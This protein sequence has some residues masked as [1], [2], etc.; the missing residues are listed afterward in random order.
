MKSPLLTFISVLFLSLLFSQNELKANPECK[1]ALESSSCE[2]LSEDLLSTTGE[3]PCYPP[4]WQYTNGITQNSATFQW[5]PVY[6]ASYYTVQWRYPG[7]SWNNVQGYCYQTWINVYNFQPCTSY[8]WRVRSHCGSGYYSS[9]CYPVY[10]TTLCYVCPNPTGCYHSDLNCSSVNLNWSGVW[11]AQGYNVQIRTYNG[12]WTNVPGSPCQSNW[13]SVYNLQPGTWYE[14]RVRVVCY[15]GYSDWSYT[16]N[17]YTSCYDY[18]PSPSWLQ[19][20][21]ITGYSATWKWQEVYGADYYSIQWRYPGGAWY[22]LH[23]GPFYGTWVNVYHLNPCT[24]YEW[25]VKSHCHY[26]SSS[27]NWCSPYTFTSSCHSVCPAPAG[28][29]TIDIG[30]TRATLKWAPVYGA[31]SYTVQIKDQWGNWSD[32]AGSPTSGIWI[33]AYNLSPCKYYEWRVR[34]NCSDG[35]YSYW[36][37]PQHFSTTCGNG[38]DR[39]LSVYTNGITSSSA[40][41]HWQP[42]NAADY[43]IVEYRVSGGTWA[44]WPGGP[45]SN[46]VLEITGLLANTTY[47]WRVKAHCLNGFSPWSSISYFTTSGSTCGM[48]FFRYTLPITDSTATFNWS[49]VAGAVNYRVQIRPLNGQWQDVAGS[50]TTAT[51]ITATGLLPNTMYEWQMQV[52]CGHGALSPWLGVVMFITGNS[53]GCGTPNGLF[54]DQITL[55]SATLHWNA[56]P[57]AIAYS[58]EIQAAPNGG[59]IA[60]TGSP[61]DTNFIV[62]DS[63]LPHATYEWRV[64]ATCAGDVHSFWSGPALFTTSD[65]PL[66][67]APIGLQSGSVTE[68]TGILSWLPVS[69]ASAY[70]LQTRLP[71]GTWIDY[72]G[73]MILDTSVLIT[74][75]TAN[76]IY[77]WQVRAL[78]NS[79]Q[80]SNWSV[81]ATFTT[82]GLGQINNDC[83]GAISLTVDNS[84][85]TTLA[86][87]VGATASEPPPAGGCGSNGYRDVWFKFTIPD[88]PN[89]TVTIRTTAGSLTNA[90][91]EVYSGTECSIM[92]LIACEDN[93]DNG[94]GSLMPVLS[95]TGGPNTTIWVRVWGVDGSTGTFDICVFNY[96]SFD[97]AIAPGSE[98]PDD[99]AQLIELQEAFPVM[100][101]DRKPALHVAPNPVRDELK[102]RVVQTEGNRL[103]GLRIV[104]LSGK[105]VLT[106]DIESAGEYTFETKVDVSGLVP[107]IYVLHVQ[108]SGGV[109]AE[110]ISVIR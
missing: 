10:F 12:D 52:N 97:L 76:T 72:P 13:I 78:C 104:D 35:G 34:A 16:G 60:V 40:I 41:L 95:L 107:G 90:V 109:M 93:N 51:S 63:L 92:S 4:D 7:G 59:W 57:G 108:T 102:V 18:C 42:L 96:I 85:I 99:G 88:V 47:E 81:T 49:P 21:N 5:D 33:T 26:G 77:E 83:A 73:G 36:S 19:C 44:E 80:F 22:D 3:N 11:E 28:M 87:N 62:V 106:Q 64:K 67:N 32:V 6:G 46:S 25:R 71:N 8:E 56:V 75:L 89:P 43:Y 50:P 9:W 94:N 110:K 55:T 27:S 100:Q 30:D 66:C 23:G 86:S 31:H 53:Q 103:I 79:G 91:M 14:W 38:C 1:A 61:V 48:P 24:T 84:C 20:Y 82:T 15:S 74:G 29:H 101:L 45:T 69:G 39:P 54:A 68:T 65:A 17:F 70:Q 105:I 2:Y 37:A 98:A 58:V